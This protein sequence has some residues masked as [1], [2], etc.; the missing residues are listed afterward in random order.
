MNNFAKK[1]IS[2]LLSA[3]LLLSVSAASAAGK[4]RVDTDRNYLKYINGFQD[5][6]VRPDAILT[7]AQGAKMLYNVLDLDTQRQGKNFTDVKTSHWA[8]PAISLLGAENLLN[9]YS[10]GV[11]K[12]DAG[13][14]RGE[15]ASIMVRAMEI[16]SIGK[17]NVRFKD[18]SGHW[19]EANITALAD[20]GFIGGYS[21]GTFKPNSFLTRAEAV[22]IINKAV[23]MQVK[24][25]AEDTMVFSDL[26]ANHW[27]YYEIL[28][29]ASS[30]ALEIAPNRKGVKFSN[31]AYSSLSNR[32]FNAEKDKLISDFGS[33]NTARRAE[34]FSDLTKL[35]LDISNAIIMATLNASRDISDSNIKAD[36]AKI[37]EAQ[38]L[39]T[40]IYKSQYEALA[41]ASDRDAIC[42]KIGMRFQD[43]APPSEPMEQ[44]LL[45]LMNRE[46]SYA[47]EF[48][49]FYDTPSLSY[50]GKT[51]SVYQAMYSGNSD[52]QNLALD[53]YVKNEQKLNGIF[54]KLVE[55]RTEI[56]EYYNCENYYDA[57]YGYYEE[58]IAAFR[59]DVKKYLVPIYK[60]IRQAQYATLN[61]AK[62]NEYEFPNVS[63]M[64]NKE[65]LIDKT[66]NVLRDLSPQ[67]RQAID[68]M[69][70][71]EMIDWE[72]RNNKASGAFT[73]YI[74]NPESPFL[75]MSA[76]GGYDDVHTFSHEF[77]HSFQNFRWYGNA[78]NKNIPLDVAET[79]ST[80][81][82]LLMAKRFDEFF[83]E[84]GEDAEQYLIY[85]FLAQII[86]S[87][88]I[89]EFQTEIYKNPNMTPTQ[90]NNLYRQLDEEYWGEY[91]KNSAHPAYLKG[92]VWSNAS[93]IYEV[94]FY[95]IEYALSSAVSL[96]IWEISKTDFDKAF[97]TYMSIIESRYARFGLAALTL[98]ADLESPFA[99]ETMSG[100]AKMIDNLFKKG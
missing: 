83:G 62:K 17:R 58:N 49:V 26:N 90:R 89:D 9:G 96:Q 44:K 7:R 20:A 52:L 3:A 38:N 2:L 69:I 11:F 25:N 68:Y 86:D 13:L 94:P 43:L 97:E 41:N 42:S 54:D 71:Y 37:P 84:Y 1:G 32:D 77:G 51:Y 57:A 33:A 16:N 10:G 59:S 14:T 87:C 30:T 75:F 93:H 82:E 92:L 35:Q 21:D 98:G 22:K 15:F 91:N 34:I 5:G 27:A 56:A 31:I 55:V 100:I 65:N 60:K 19:A 95:M 80:A 24:T 76:T 67:T 48:G 12:P 73:T 74:M 53:Y 45:E 99:E 47:S 28:S 85:Y 4:F 79:A 6:S 64:S 63:F 72:V 78:P 29:A 61:A 70:K 8:Y 88:M 66:Q 18:V 46:S 39:L 50:D 40:E 81:M 23:N 36:Y